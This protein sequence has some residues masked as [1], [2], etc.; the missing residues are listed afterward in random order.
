MKKR[1]LILLLV[2]A[3]LICVLA[4]CS[5][6]INPSDDAANKQAN[7]EQIEGSEYLAYSVDTRVVYYMF[8][9]WESAGYQGYGYAYFA[10]YISE[11]G[12]FCRYVN[13][14]I[15][16]ITREPTTPSR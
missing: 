7:F 3:L 2:V 12:N 10:P 1:T 5:T 8:S 13:D 11:N 9:T 15:V 4:A 16:E 6:S 14:E